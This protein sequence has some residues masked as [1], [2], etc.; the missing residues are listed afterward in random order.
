MNL[1]NLTNFDYNLPD[2]LIA[3]EPVTPRSASKLLVYSD[4]GILDAQFKS[5][6][7]Y[8]K[9]NDR[10]VFNDTKVLN[11]RL[12]GE[13]VRSSSSGTGIAKIESLLLEKISKN[14]WSAFCKPLKKLQVSEY[15]NFSTALRAQVISIINNHC[16]LQFSK[17]GRA[18]AKEISKIGQLP[19][20][21]YILKNRKYTDADTLNY[22]SIFA[23]KYGAIA[24]P[25]AGLHFD[26]ALLK[27]L[28]NND[29][30]F[31][32]VTLHVG[33]GTFLPVTARN[34][35][36]HEMHSENGVITKMV[37]D[38]I[39]RTKADGGRIISVGTTSLR[40]I[41][42][43]A[44]SQREIKPFNG[45]TNIFIRPGYKFKMTDGLITNFH[46]PKSTLLMLISAFVG[47]KERIKIYNHALSNQ[48][49]FF[50]YGDSS[51]LIRS[52]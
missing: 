42:S 11:A 10:L 3:L 36:D 7:K 47:N 17:T 29:I 35:S 16:I 41:E 31:S 39:N 13:R 32:F 33:A 21:P 46:F 18:L 34:I 52:I 6:F 27:K 26:S 1:N 30:K 8:L 22:Q 4:G 23:K 14:Q 49:R 9:P 15:I 38:D 28:K 12:F 25:T 45:K 51:L 48:Y 24:S 2:H 19:L 44:I 20:P 50:S 37:A 5:L 43:A 40:L